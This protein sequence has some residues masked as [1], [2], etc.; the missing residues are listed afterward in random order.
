MSSTPNSQQLPILLHVHAP[1]SRRGPA[2][3]VGTRAALIALRDAVDQALLG[4][5]AQFEAA[6]VDGG[7]YTVGIQCDD[8]GKE[9][10]VWP[11]RAAPYAAPY[12]QEQRAYAIWPEV[13]SI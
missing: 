7:I 13:L 12:A 10:P 8:T 9:G 5:S 1:Y 6:A 3:I 4:G 11:L 2:A